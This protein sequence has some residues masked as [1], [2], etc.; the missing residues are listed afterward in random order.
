MTPVRCGG[1]Q[2]R[3]EVVRAKSVI[4]NAFL[5]KG[6]RIVKAYLVVHGGEVLDEPATCSG[7][8]YCDILPCRPNG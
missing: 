3:F 6:P 5:T 2:T 4:E 7:V 8:V 1:R